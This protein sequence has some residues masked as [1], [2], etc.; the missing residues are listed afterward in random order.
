MILLK[1]VEIQCPSFISIAELRHS[2]KKQ[3]K[4]IGFILSYSPLLQGSEGGRNLK[5]QR[6]SS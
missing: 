4:E 5:Q 1:A 3:L 6:A 2:D